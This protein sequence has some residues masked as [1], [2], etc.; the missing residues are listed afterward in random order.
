MNLGIFP[1]GGHKAPPG[2]KRSLRCHVDARVLLVYACC[3][4]MPLAYVSIFK[5][6]CSFFCDISCD[7]KTE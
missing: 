7:N 3:I 5:P 4:I 6:R 1:L 2:A